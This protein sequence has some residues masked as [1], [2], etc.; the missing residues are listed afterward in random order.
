[1]GHEWTSDHCVLSLPSQ[2]EPTDVVGEILTIPPTELT[3][4]VVFG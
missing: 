3:R 1:M 4:A 2:R